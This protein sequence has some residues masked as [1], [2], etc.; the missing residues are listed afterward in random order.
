MP[1]NDVKGLDD[2]LKFLDVA[3]EQMRVS[4]DAGAI[5]GAALIEARAKANCPVAPPNSENA[6]LYGG[7]YGALRDSI[8]VT[9]SNQKGRVTAYISAGGKTA[10]GADIYYAHLI[11]FSGAAPHVIKSRSGKDI[12]F[13][14]HSY[15]EVHHPGFKAHPFLRPALDSSE[16]E[17]VS[18]IDQAIDSLLKT[19]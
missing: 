8:H 10:A 7:Y 15:S 17:A 4:I 1:N 5:A 3:P 12:S 6:R 2:F 19:N 9:M 13:G 11:E 16:L 14:G 18:L